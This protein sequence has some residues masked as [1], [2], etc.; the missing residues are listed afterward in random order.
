[1]DPPNCRVFIVSGTCGKM[2]RRTFSKNISSGNLR[3]HK[4]FF[5]VL[6]VA[7]AATAAAAADDDDDDGR[8]F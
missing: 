3:V 7:V 6:V 4:L 5:F 2:I 1:M 8:E